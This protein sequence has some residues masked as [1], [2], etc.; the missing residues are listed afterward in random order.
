MTGF[1]NKSHIKKRNMQSA[2]SRDF[3]MC[4]MV[5]VY[6]I[7]PYFKSIKQQNPGGTII[8]N[9]VSLACMTMIN[10]AMGWF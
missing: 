8:K 1:F 6:L 7:G 3:R 10:L 5:H 2:T 9:N 4:D